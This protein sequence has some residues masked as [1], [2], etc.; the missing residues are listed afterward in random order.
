V[1]SCVNCCI[2]L[3]A[4]SNTPHLSTPIMQPPI[5]NQDGIYNGP[6]R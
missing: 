1:P 3:M 2:K 4:S 5:D 6:R